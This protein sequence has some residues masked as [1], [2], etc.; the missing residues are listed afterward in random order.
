[1]KQKKEDTT[2]A[3]PPPLQINRQLGNWMAVKFKDP[4]LSGYWATQED[5]SSF[6][7]MGYELACPEDI[8]DFDRQFCDINPG[9]ALSPEGMI[10]YHSHTL[11]KVTKA[12]QKQV[13]QYFYKQR[14]LYKNKPDYLGSIKRRQP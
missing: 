5:I 4:N 1:M 8:Q 10:S 9:E 12:R 6:K 14:E 7:N 3:P 11:L 2:V 13:E